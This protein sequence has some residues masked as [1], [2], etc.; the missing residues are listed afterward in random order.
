MTNSGA[1]LFIS[2]P[3]QNEDTA[4][5]FAEKL[6]KAGI[7]VWAFVDS[8]P[9]KLSREDQLAHV[10]KA[11]ENATVF[12]VLVSPFTR[13]SVG[14][15]TE[16][17]YAQSRNLTILPVVIEA[18]AEPPINLLRYSFVDVSSLPPDEAISQIVD[19]ID[20]VLQSEKSH[21]IPAS[22]PKIV[23]NRVNILASIPTARVFIAY[24]HRQQDIARKLS[25][26]LTANGVPN[27]YDAKIKAG[28]TW[29]KMIQQA[30]D[31]S[32]HLIVIWTPEASTSDEVEREVS[33]ALAERKI[34]VP[35][36]SKDIPK[37]PYHLHGLHY[38]TLEQEFSQIEFGLLNAIAQ[39]SGNEDIWQ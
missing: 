15:A 1:R 9:P 28:A 3:I 7:E 35:L 37:L 27:F 5:V 26:L 21:I 17:V 24:S 38:I 34:I 18:A 2:Y 14:A 39:R 23:H 13:K 30:L 11:I 20:K 8:I 16:I 25:E 22:P 10:Q 19:E 29:R 31:D 33:Y 36:L 6:R 12:V 32:T 4:R